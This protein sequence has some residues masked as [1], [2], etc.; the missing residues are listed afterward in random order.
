MLSV[1]LLFLPAVLALAAR[2]LSRLSHCRNDSTSSESASSSLAAPT[3]VSFGPRSNCF[4]ALG[5]K[6]PSK[7]PGSIYGWWCNPATEYAFLGF[8]YEVTACACVVIQRVILVAL[9]CP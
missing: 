8:S 3:S 7:V 4:P 5:F 9:A 6:M 1:L 2:P